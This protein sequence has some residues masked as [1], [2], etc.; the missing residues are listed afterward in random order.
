MSWNPKKERFLQRRVDML[1]GVQD[2]TSRSPSVNLLSPEGN[3]HKGEWMCL[4]ILRPWMDFYSHFFLLLI[5]HPR[6]SPGSNTAKRLSLT[7]SSPA[8]ANERTVWRPGHGWK[9]TRLRKK[10]LSWASTPGHW[11][12]GDQPRCVETLMTSRF[13]DSGR[14]VVLDEENVG[15]D[16]PP[17]IC[18]LLRDL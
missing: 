8:M 11:L 6:L 10:P 7:E 9:S 13:P 12:L 1:V 15:N 5:S 17:G 3:T 4:W 18:S 2:S 16:R 14:P